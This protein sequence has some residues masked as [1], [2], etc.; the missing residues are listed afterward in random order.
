M[1]LTLIQKKFAVLK[2]DPEMYYVDSVPIELSF[3]NIVLVNVGTIIISYLVLRLSTH[4][5]KFLK[6]FVAEAEAC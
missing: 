6:L 4:I 3:F 1:T 5:I 2:L